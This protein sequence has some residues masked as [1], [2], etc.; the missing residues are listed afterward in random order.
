VA[1]LDARAKRKR[2]H[3]LLALG[4]LANRRGDEAEVGVGVRRPEERAQNGL[5][6]EAEERLPGAP[7]LRRDT[8]GRSQAGKVGEARDV[9]E[10][11]MRQHEL[12]LLHTRKR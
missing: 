12:E 2:T 4:Q 6:R 9:V 1:R 3:L 11:E 8:A 7:D 10:V 5:T